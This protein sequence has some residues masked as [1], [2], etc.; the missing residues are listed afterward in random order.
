MSSEASEQTWIWK[1]EESDLYL[2]QD[3]TIRFRVEEEIFIDC[4][5]GKKGQV[6]EG[7]SPYSLTGSAQVSGL[8]SISWWE[9]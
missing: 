8:G 6:I 4:T 2:D 7:I 3:E 9:D 5:P 1:T